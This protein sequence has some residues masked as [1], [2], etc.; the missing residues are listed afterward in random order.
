MGQSLYASATAAMYR[1]P[2]AGQVVYRAQA[3]HQSGPKILAM[4]A[5][6]GPGLCGALARYDEGR[7]ALPMPLFCMG[8][9]RAAAWLV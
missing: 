9:R 6:C 5:P 3:R 7:S 8:F 4:C 2:R 1:A